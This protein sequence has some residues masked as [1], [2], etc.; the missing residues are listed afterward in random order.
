VRTQL[1]GHGV[2][3]LLKVTVSYQTEIVCTVP[4]NAAD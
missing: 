2:D 4:E 3:F 1:G